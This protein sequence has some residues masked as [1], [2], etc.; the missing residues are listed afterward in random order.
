MDDLVN[1]CENV[2]AY[3]STLIVAAISEMLGAVSGADA[4][5]ATQSLLAQLLKR[6]KYGL[7]HPDEIV[8]Y[9]LGFADRIAVKIKFDSFYQTDRKR[10]SDRG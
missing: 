7:S 8:L 2:I 5:S 6:M 3:D 4:A 1:L 9:E 10:V